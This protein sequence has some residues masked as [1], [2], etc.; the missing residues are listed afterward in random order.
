MILP[1][2]QDVRPPS[3]ALTNPDMI[4]PYNARLKDT[5]TPTQRMGSMST[6]SEFTPPHSS[7]PIL[8][9]SW[10]SEED[11]RPG[12]SEENYLRQPDM[13]IAKLKSPVGRFLNTIDPRMKGGIGVEVPEYSPSIYSPTDPEG[14]TP[15]GYDEPKPTPFTSAFHGDTKSSHDGEEEDEDDDIM[16]TRAEEILANAKKRLLVQYDSNSCKACN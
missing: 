10:L 15:E 16:G 7:R 1:H 12:Q 13:P 11:V 8:P 14:R 4:L 5:D 3:P 9:G 2:P 6:P